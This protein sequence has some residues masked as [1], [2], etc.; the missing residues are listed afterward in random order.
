MREKLISHTRGSCMREELIIRHCSPT[1][2]GIKTGS[3]F[4]C[5]YENEEMLYDDLRALNKNLIPRGVR[6]LPVRYYGNRALI[7][8]YRPERLSRD[9]SDNDAL[10]LLKA[11][12]YHCSCTDQYVIQLMKRLK[13]SEEFPHEIGLFLGYPPSD[14]KG[15]IDNHGKACK[16]SGCW[17]VY[18]DEQ[19]ACRLFEKYR[20]CTEIYCLKCAQGVSIDRLTV[21]R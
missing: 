13:A 21:A 2:A 12:G 6:I 4:N 19:S 5:S 10:A 7:Y 15:F 9:L 11:R 20:R 8:L 17:K 3:L 16:Y 14:V 18:S 1:L